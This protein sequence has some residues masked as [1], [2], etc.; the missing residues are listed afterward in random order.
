MKEAKNYKHALLTR[1][2]K[3]GCRKFQMYLG[4]GCLPAGSES[5]TRSKFESI[6]TRYFSRSTWGQFSVNVKLLASAWSTVEVILSKESSI[7]ALLSFEV[8]S[9]TSSLDWSCSLAKCKK[10]LNTILNTSGYFS[11]G[12]AMSKLARAIL[13]TSGLGSKKLQYQRGNILQRW[14]PG[15]RLAF[16][17][18]AAKVSWVASLTC[19]SGSFIRMRHMW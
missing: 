15:L 4:L 2:R 6:L 3:F 7:K 10:F 9:F 19:L 11:G 16:R 5:I 1:P 13:A 14:G 17:M 8:P 12:N 18:N